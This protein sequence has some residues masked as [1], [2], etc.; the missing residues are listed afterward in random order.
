VTCIIFKLRADVP[1][2]TQDLLLENIKAWDS[3]NRAGRL[4]SQAQTSGQSVL[5]YVY[6]ADEEAVRTTLKR[7][8]E[9]RE[10]EY[11]HIPAPREA[12]PLRD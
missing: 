4:N 8:Q 9:T 10:V 12:A 1:A 11:A 3:N 5:Y 7:L 6:V 2:Q